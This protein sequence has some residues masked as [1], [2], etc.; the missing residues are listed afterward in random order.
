MLSVAQRARSG[1]QLQTITCHSSIAAKASH[2]V[3]RR[4]ILSQDCGN[5]AILALCLDLVDL[6]AGTIM[7]QQQLRN[8]L[9][10]CL[11]AFTKSLQA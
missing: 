11:K 2:H 3:S 9:G 5:N 7:Q 1:D 8:S 4:L 10:P 6:L